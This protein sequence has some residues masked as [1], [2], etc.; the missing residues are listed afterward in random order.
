MERSVVAHLMKTLMMVLHTVSYSAGSSQVSDM[1]RTCRGASADYELGWRRLTSEVAEVKGIDGAVAKNRV[2]SRDSS[3]T[4]ALLSSAS[5]AADMR[6]TTRSRSRPAAAGSCSG[7]MPE[8]PQVL[9][10]LT[11]ASRRR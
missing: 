2:A 11:R 8:H 3:T 9:A 1:S 10:T 4:E 6:S 7:M 5:R